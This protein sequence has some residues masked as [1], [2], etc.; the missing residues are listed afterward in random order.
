LRERAEKK[1]STQEKNEKE[2][3]LQVEFKTPVMDYSGN[4]KFSF[5]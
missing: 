2:K 3:I 5:N 1:N 4:I